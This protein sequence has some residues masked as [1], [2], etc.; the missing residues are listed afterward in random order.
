MGDKVLDSV[1]YAIVN[2]M[3]LCCMVLVAYLVAIVNLQRSAR[4]VNL[5]AGNTSANATPE[6][7]LGPVSVGP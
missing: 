5:K 3:I 7:Q 1:F 2:E 4:A 6:I